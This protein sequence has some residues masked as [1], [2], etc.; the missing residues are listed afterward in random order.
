MPSNVNYINDYQ[1]TLMFFVHPFFPFREGRLPGSVSIWIKIS[2][3][4]IIGL[5]SLH[6]PERLQGHIG[7]YS[8]D[9]IH[10]A[11]GELVDDNFCG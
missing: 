11:R 4:S 2:K 7:I 1:R 9:M 3:K 5:Q 8:T 10:I 6:Q